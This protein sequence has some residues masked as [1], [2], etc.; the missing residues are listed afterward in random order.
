MA[1]TFD[2]L[3]EKSQF[4]AVPVSADAAATIAPDELT[5]AGI[6]S[7]EQEPSDGERAW[8]TM[9]QVA[10]EVGTPMATGIAA[11]PLLAAGPF[12]WAAYGVIQLASGMGSNAVAQK[13]RNPEEDWNPEEGIASG[14]F[15]AIPGLQATK[16]A[17]LGKVGTV[18]VRAGEGAVMAGGESL[19]RQALEMASEKRESLDPFEIGFATIGG[20]GVGGVLG[21]VEAT[22]GFNRLGVSTSDAK[23]IQKRVES[24]VAERVNTIDKIVKNPDLKGDVRDALLKERDELKAQIEIISKTDAEYVD[25]LREKA[26]EEQ[27][28]AERVLVEMLDEAGKTGTVRNIPEQAVDKG[29]KIK[30]KPVSATPTKMTK[31]QKLAAVERM[32]MSDEDLTSFLEGKTEILPLN[33]ARFSSESDIQ[34]S[35]A[36]V[37]EQIGDKIKSKRGKLDRDTLIKTAARLRSKLDPSIDPLKYAEEVA[38]EADDLIFKSAVADSM[39]FHAFNSWSKK[40]DTNPDFNNPAVVNDLLADLERLGGFAEAS[41]K[42]G[43]S[44][45]RL[46]QSRKIFRDQ[47]AASVSEMERKATKL[48]KGLTS[49]LLKYSKDLKPSELKAQIEKLGGLKSLRGFLN[50]LRVVR[51][52]K[53]LGK[54]LEVSRK[55]RI[56]RVADAFMELR[57]D[58]MLSGPQTQAAAAFGNALMS[59]YSLTNQAVGGLATGNLQASKMAVRTAKNMLFVQKDAFKA[60]LTAAKNS[61]GQMSLSTHYEKVGG[62]ALAVEATGLKG[63]VGESIENIGELLS[64]GPKGLVFQDEFYR[65][66]FAKAQVRSLLTEE[67]NQMLRKGEIKQGTLDQFIEGRMSRYFVDGKR[68]KTKQDI[69]L[70]GVRSAQEL[71]L[72]GDEAKE[73]IQRYIKDNWNEKLSSELEYL[74][75]F[76]D[77]VTFQQDLS[78]DYGTFEKLGSYVQDIRDDSYIVQYAVPFIKTPVNIFKEAGG[79]MSIMGDIPGVRNLWARTQAELNSENPLIRAQARGRQLVGGALWMSAVYLADQKLITSSGPQNYRELENKR[80]T[81]WQPNALNVTGFK[82]YIETGESEGDKPGDKYVSLT[83][84]D[85]VATL[86]GLAADLLRAKEDN[87]FPEEQFSY[88]LNT[89]AFALTEAVGQK[90]YLETVGSALE[91]LTSGRATSEDAAIGEAFLE[92]LVRGNTPS[93]LNS[94]GRSDDPYIREVNGPLEMLKNRLPG[95]I[96][97]LDP[98]RNQ[99]GQKVKSSYDRLTTELNTLLPTKLSEATNDK[100]LQ[101]IA[102]VRGAY[103]FPKSDRVIKGLDLKQFKVEGSNQSLYDRWKELYSELP[104]AETVIDVYENPDISKMKRVPRGSPLTDYRK[105]AVSDVLAGF[106][107]EALG[108]LLEEYPELEEQFE[109][110]GELQLKQIEGEEVPSDT[111]APSLQPLLEQ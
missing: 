30:E 69:E 21:R 95:F 73:H 88:W 65:H 1:K 60:A 43:T 90:S 84:F 19:T 40:M 46:L 53:K 62:K 3:Y 109:Y 52:P 104:V 31:E 68:Y 101:I 8:D 64:F 39:T 15:S 48:E 41:S 4:K 25:R 99:L 12:G 54:L 16:I 107:E 35:M 18:S 98:K 14:V 102:E 82:R 79:A 7:I 56:A 70:E 58:F 75:D 83:R 106:R 57:Y 110:M 80:N 103:A 67:Y 71:E 86:T 32:G 105:Q 59:A 77:R 26:K 81:G 111:L 17:K 9:K 33:I 51:D 45:G 96:Q 5:S 61:Q 20:A 89:V 87:D 6:L 92:E 44:A 85:P 22:S 94:L 100:A 28:N 76:G 29:L 23:K 47:I 108:L 50:E 36:S 91:A 78:K 49:E 63:A 72:D 13:M 74:Q 24:N 11:S 42:I 2:E 66:M 34:K 27:T 97:T 55:G 38:G 10:V 93:I 37:L